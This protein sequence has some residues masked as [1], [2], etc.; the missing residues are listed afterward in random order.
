MIAATNITLRYGRNTVLDDLSFQADPGQFT[1][2]VGPNGSGKT[3][4]LKALTGEMPIDGKVSVSGCDIA[5]TPAWHLATLRAV[6]PQATVLSFPFQAL[7]VVRLGQA[8]NTMRDGTLPHQA[9]ARVGLSG[10][11][12][13]FYQ[14]LSGGE[15]QRVQL[16]RVLCQVWTPVENGTPRWLL[17]DE[18]VSSLDIGHQL[19][20]M[21]IARD[22]ANAGGGV[23]AVMHDLN[24]SAMFADRV[25]LMKSGA[26]LADGTAS[27]VLTDQNVSQ[28]YEC[29]VQTRTVPQDQAWFL[30]PQG[31]ALRPD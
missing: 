4:L 31:A 12:H 5:A 3:S 30:L 14:E 16:A 28:T 22:Y 18:P 25:V 11:E 13:R 10:Y 23:I 9:L 6:L 24:L 19:E 27:N 20:I 29:R 2:I 26:I 21:Q 1:A 15:Q 7:E 8:R 17:L